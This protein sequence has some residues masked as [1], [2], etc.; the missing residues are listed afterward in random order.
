MPL[1]DHA[2]SP[3]AARELPERSPEIPQVMAHNAYDADVYEQSLGKHEQLAEALVG[4]VGRLASAPNLMMDLY[5]SFIKRAPR[6]EDAECDAA[7]YRLNR[8]LIEQVMATREHAGVRDAGTP[9]DPLL[10]AIATVATTES[11]LA[12]IDDAT[13]EKVNRAHELEQRA[14]EAFD[15]ADQLEE[16][17]EALP[18]DREQ[19]VHGLRHDAEVNRQQAREAERERELTQQSLDAGADE[20]EDAVRRAARAAIA[21]ARAQIEELNAAEAA[22]AL[23]A[24]SGGDGQGSSTLSPDEKLALMKRIRG[25][26][27]LKQLLEVAGRLKPIAL[28]MQRKKVQY[29]PA[30]LASVVVGSDIARVIPGE[31]ALL[32]DEDTED[33]FFL[34]FIEGKLLQYELVG[35]EPKGRGPLLIALDDSGSMGEPIPGGVRGLTKEA[36]AKGVMLA[37]LSI[38]RLQARD[39]A[40]IHFSGEGQ[41]AVWRF[42][43]EGKADYAR[44]IE[45][46]EIFFAGGTAYRPWMEAALQLVGEA[47]YDRADTIL[48]SDG[49]AADL[50]PGLAERWNGMRA[51]RE[52]R[53]YSVLI[54]GAAGEA[55]LSSLSDALLALDTLADERTVLTS[56]FGL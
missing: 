51:E 27:L 33:L 53:A 14:R 6:M 56:V 23:G 18:P 30:E 29:P 52:M 2:Q 46:A 26:P 12:A 40:V 43:K 50:T 22:F 8:R 36:Y 25:N 11:A 15:A 3:E 24:G 37:L 4:A 20:L 16:E 9:G 54:G 13:L 28:E 34:R 7:A 31:L 41:L 38:A 35:N 10:S 5:N 48:L 47:E 45:C 39:A 32:M 42:P 1:D 21:G 55:A 49:V 17:A 19:E 44:V